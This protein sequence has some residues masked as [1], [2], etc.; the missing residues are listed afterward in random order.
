MT[1]PLLDPPAPTDVRVVE[2]LLRALAKGQRALQMYLPNNPV[3]QRSVEQV[4]EAFGPVWGVTGRLVL[5]LQD[6]ELQWEGAPLHYGASRTEGFAAQLHQDGLR[7]L[8]LLPGVESEEI[9]RFLAVMNRARLLPK[10]ASD[11]LLTLLWEQQFVLIAYTFVEALSDG[12][13][14]LQSGGAAD[15]AQDPGAVREQVEQDPGGAVAPADL[16]AAPFFLDEAELRLMQSELEEEYRRDIRTAAIDALLDVLEGQREPAVRRE[17]VALLEDVLPSQLAVGGF[18]AV[19]RILRELRVIAV[20]AAGLEQSLHDA[21]LSFEERL[22]QPDILEQLF[23]TLEDP[24]TRPAEDEIGEV[25][26]ELKPGALPIVLVHLGRSIAPEIRRALLPSVEQLARSRPQALQEVLDAGSSDAVEPAIDLVARLG[27]SALVP[28]VA[29]RLV[30]GTIGVRVAALNALG[31]FATPSAITAI[32]SAL[33]DE[34]RT[35]RQTALT[36]LLARGGS[37]G[38]LAKLE[39]LLFAGKDQDWERSERRALFEAYGQLAGPAAITRLRELLAPRGLLRRKELPDVRACAIFAL[40]KIRTF[41]A[42]LVVDQFTADKEAIVRSAAN[43][44]L[45][46]WLA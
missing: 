15:A 19:A 31:G 22:S 38:T 21:I 41:E 7:R 33:T 37:G 27:L 9:T 46:D 1:S 44:V 10:D 18:R 23:R 42:R 14:F 13:E 20:R 45:R 24:A 36:I 2:E 39:A 6:G 29:A 17:V 43:A 28:S 5:D 26:R 35:V 3:Y 25:L 11:D 30:D 32:E 40:A 16:D 4:A 34:E 12:V 8:V